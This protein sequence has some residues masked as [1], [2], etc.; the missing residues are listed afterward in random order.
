MSRVV[1][2]TDVAAEITARRLREWPAGHLFR[3]KLGQPW[4]TDAVNNMFGRLRTRIGMDRMRQQ[5]LE[6]PKDEVERLIPTLARTRRTKGKLVQ[7]PDK[8]LIQEARRKATNAM[9]NRFVPRLSLY[10]IRHTWATRAL[11]TGVDP[12]TTAILMG[13]SDPS[14]LSKVYQ[15]VALNPAHMLEQAKRAAGSPR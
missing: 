13:H 1:Y 15:H 11:Q 3:N 8:L 5:G 4:T 14:M 7:K 2:L 12:L 6:V 10:A 9:A